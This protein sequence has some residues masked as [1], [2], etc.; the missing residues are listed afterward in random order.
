MVLWRHCAR[1]LPLKNSL[2]V[3]LAV[4]L[5]LSCVA[6]AKPAVPPPTTSQAQEAIPVP[7]CNP[8]DP[9]TPGGVN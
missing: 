1:S 4:V 3:A 5:G 8:D 7:L 9:C 6:A 2:I